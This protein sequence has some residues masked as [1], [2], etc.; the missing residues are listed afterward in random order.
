M[1]NVLKISEAASLA[2]HTAV[3]LAYHQGDLVSTRQIS[4]ALGVSEAHLSKVL[5][6]LV[7]EGLVRSIRGPRGGFAL[8]RQPDK[9]RLIEVYEAIEGTLTATNCLL[10]KQVCDGAS[11]IL[12]GLLAVTNRQVR[13][14][15]SSAR[16]SE[17][18]GA[19]RSVK[20]DVEESRKD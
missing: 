6:R 7:R 9:I 1:A 4:E 11:C 15:L 16:V 17:L 5:Q 19:Y 20:H 14:Y 3:L 10:G 13:E 18:T 2:M 12:G 8:A